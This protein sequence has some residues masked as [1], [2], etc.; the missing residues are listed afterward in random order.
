VAK[1]ILSRKGF[2]SKYGGGCSPILPNGDMLSIPIPT[3]E[4]EEG[5]SYS[6]IRY[7]DK[8]YLR[9]MEELEIC[10][11]EHKKCHFDPDLIRGAYKRKENW[12][13]IFGQQG[14]ALSHLQNQN[15]EEGDIFLF[16]GSF[17]STHYSHKL[18]FERDYERH[19]IFGYLIIGKILDPQFEQ[20]SIFR[21]HPHFQNNDIYTPLNRVY[22]ANSD[23]DFG[24]FK[25]RNDLV[26][27]K[28]GFPK[29]IWEL[30]MIFH[31]DSG[32]TISR[33]SDKNFEKRGDTLLFTSQNIGQDFV[34]SGGD[35]IESWA[36]AIIEN[37]EKINSLNV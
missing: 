6:E 15:I 19:I 10:I 17:R 34:V 1:V 7:G 4:R 22:I 11:P 28:K 13:G 3:N 27:T 25:Y 5:I 12:T 31:P 14:S 20:N 9:L 18:R 21:E 35:E 29:S 8:T 36:R 2:D 32:T 37:S 23:A 16:F 24:V 26:L 33:H 30:P